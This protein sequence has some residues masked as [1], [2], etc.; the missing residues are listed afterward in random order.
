MLASASHMM[1]P[2]YCAVTAGPMSHS[3]PPMAAPAIMSPGPSIARIP[4]FTFGGSGSSPVL[5][6]GIW[7]VSISRPSSGCAGS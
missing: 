7:P 6:G 5:H 1:M 2:P 3:P 4:R